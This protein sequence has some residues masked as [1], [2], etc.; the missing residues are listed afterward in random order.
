ML[1]TRWRPA[2]RIV[3]NGGVEQYSRVMAR[4]TIDVPDLELVEALAEC[5]GLA[6]AAD[7]LHVTPSALSH[8]LRQ[9][10][11]RL[12]VRLFVRSSRHMSPTS[13]GE[14]VLRVGMPVL[15]EL[16]RAEDEIGVRDAGRRGILRIS[17]ET[18]PSYHWLPDILERFQRQ[19]PKVEVRVLDGIDSATD[20]LVDHRLD[21]AIVMRSLPR[22]GI[23]CVPLFR[24]EMT[25]VMAD[26][27]PLADKPYVSPADLGDSRLMA[28]PGESCAEWSDRPWRIPLVDLMFDLIR[29]DLGVGLLP[30]WIAAPALRTGGLAARRLTQDGTFRDWFVAH[31]DDAPGYVSTFV[32]ALFRRPPSATAHFDTCDEAAAKPS[33]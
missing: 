13:A 22:D 27:H 24:D 11:D 8:Q 3:F 28:M 33:S 30:M 15:Q 18:Y 12:G 23:R 17:V 31:R 14:R 19:F 1:A 6:R 21:V 4:L 2:K 9:L 5:R 7:R 26:G 10:E 25:I 32:E 20:A 16:R 29:R